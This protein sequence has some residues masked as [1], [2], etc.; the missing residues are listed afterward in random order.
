MAY[1]KVSCAF[2]RSAVLS[3]TTITKRRQV[4]SDFARAKRKCSMI[5]VI[6]SSAGSL[7]SQHATSRFVRFKARD[8]TCGDLRDR[9]GWNKARK[10][11]RGAVGRHELR[12]DAQLVL[13]NH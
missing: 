11:K 12:V 2:S 6:S 8:R 3:P 7:P 13:V 9:G 10:E 4:G 5:S 1:S